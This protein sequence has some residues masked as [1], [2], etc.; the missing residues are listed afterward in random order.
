MSFIIHVT[1]IV[2]Q[3]WQ[4]TISLTSKYS[5][6]KK[7]AK[8]LLQIHEYEGKLQTPYNLLDSMIYWTVI[9]KQATPHYLSW[10][11]WTP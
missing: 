1:Q 11:S 9:I 3:L 10:H 5:L 8:L 7:Q 2:C 6:S 4:Q